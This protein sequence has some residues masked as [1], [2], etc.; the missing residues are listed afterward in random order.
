MDS[1]VYSVPI[2]FHEV[3]SAGIVFFARIFEYHH[4]AYEAWMRMIGYPLDPAAGERRYRLPLAHAEAD[5]HSPIQL[6]EDLKIRL[7]V[8]VIGTSSFAMA[9]WMG[10]SDGEDRATVKTVHVCIDRHTGRPCPLPEAFREVLAGHHK[11]DE[12]VCS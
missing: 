9:S 12:P 4:N 10:S 7:R 8:A 1:F 6:G 11:P 5:Y 3:D 2:R